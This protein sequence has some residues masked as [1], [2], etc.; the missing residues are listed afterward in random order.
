M[1]FWFL[2]RETIV[3][4]PTTATIMYY[5]TFL[6]SLKELLKRCTFLPLLVRLPSSDLKN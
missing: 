6:F 4:S 1:I 2:A 5:D 3:Q